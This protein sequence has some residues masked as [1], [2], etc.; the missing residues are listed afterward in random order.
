MLG[1]LSRKRT[2]EGNWYTHTPAIGVIA[3]AGSQ[4]GHPGLAMPLWLFE[5]IG[6]C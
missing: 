5:D 4:G 3:K 1:E 2:M 6:L